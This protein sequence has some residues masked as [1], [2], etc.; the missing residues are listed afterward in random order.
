MGCNTSQEQKAS[1][2]EGGDGA[3]ETDEQNQT[4]DDKKKSANSSK[5]EMDNGH[6]DGTASKNEGKPFPYVQA[7]ANI[8]N[9]FTYIA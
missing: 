7:I 9:R 6:I 8:F 2:N 3:G 4:N 5:S 1:V